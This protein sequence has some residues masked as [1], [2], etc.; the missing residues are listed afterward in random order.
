MTAR[1]ESET[2]AAARDADEV[3]HVGL[4]VIVSAI[5]LAAVA[6]CAE[7][8]DIALASITV[9]LTGL[10]VYSRSFWRHP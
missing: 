7:S 8:T 5:T 9:S 10:A 2:L 6:F 4:L 3:E 1:Y